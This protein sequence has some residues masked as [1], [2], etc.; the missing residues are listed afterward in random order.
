MFNRWYLSL[1]DREKILFA[2][3]S[4]VTVMLLLLLLVWRPLNSSKQQLEGAIN[5]KAGQLAEMQLTAQQIEIYRNKSNNAAITGS[6]QQR[7]T[8]TAAALKIGLTR[9][10]SNN[11]QTLQLWL[12]RVE[13]NS[14]LSLID[15]LSQQGVALNKLNLEPLPE[16]GYSKAR[17]TLIER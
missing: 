9:L 4:C 13:F 11:E 17:L 14:L 3:G 5:S 12:D 2:V 10:Q 1:S 15:R 8:Q 16:A 7:A 6:L